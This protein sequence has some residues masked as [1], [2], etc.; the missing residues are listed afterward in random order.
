[1]AYNTSH[2]KIGAPNSRV[3]MYLLDRGI[4]FIWCANM[5]EMSSRSSCIPT[6]LHSFL[7]RFCILLCC[8]WFS[9][10]N[11]DL[12]DFVITVHVR[13]EHFEVEFRIS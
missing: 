7:Q 2:T 4:L 8:L 12:S 6:Y 5:R 9:E 3:P 1:M 11:A 10:L 13:L